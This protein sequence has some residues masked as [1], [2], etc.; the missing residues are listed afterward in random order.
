M[1]WGG[2]INFI[3]ALPAQKKVGALPVAEGKIETA[4]SSV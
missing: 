1:A 3:Y 4:K 2:S